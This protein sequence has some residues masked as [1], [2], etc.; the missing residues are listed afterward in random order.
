MLSPVLKSRRIFF[1]SCEVMNMK[2][3]NA[4]LKNTGCYSV[5]GPSK[6]IN[7]DRAAIFWASFYHLMLRDNG[8]SMKRRKLQEITSDLQRLFGVSMR[9]F[10]TSDKKASGFCEVNLPTNKSLQGTPASRCP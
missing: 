7:F 5:I 10:A 9:Y 1:S 4:L 6:S 8:R 2:L 3:A